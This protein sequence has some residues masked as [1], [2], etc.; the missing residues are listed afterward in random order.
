MRQIGASILSSVIVALF[1]CCFAYEVGKTH[2]AKIEQQQQLK[3]GLEN[4]WVNKFGNRQ[5]HLDRWG[6]ECGFDKDNPSNCYYLYKATVYLNN[7]QFTFNFK[8]NVKQEV[9]TNIFPSFPEVK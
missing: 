3:I 4:G 5:F 8:Q 9:E 2:Q 1:S 6:M 7:E